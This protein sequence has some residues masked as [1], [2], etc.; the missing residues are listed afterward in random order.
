MNVPSTVRI[1]KW[2]WA[3][4]V[5]KT[6]TVST[7]ACREGHVTIAGQA[8]KPSRGI[9]LNDLILARVGEINRTVK[10]L[11]F[12]G[13]RVSATAA[14][15]FSMDLTPASEYGK[16]KDP[17][18]QPLFSRPRGAGRPTKKERRDMARIGKIF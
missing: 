9:K 16:R 10:V 8:V 7:A 17:V 11:G 5:Y 14:T 13:Q 4:R 1:D 15:A 2:L 18:L 3:V 6:R 12:P